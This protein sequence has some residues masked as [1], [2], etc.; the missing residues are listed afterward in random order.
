MWDN[1]VNSVLDKVFASEKNYP[2]NLSGQLECLHCKCS[3]QTPTKA[4]ASE[5]SDTPF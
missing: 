4:V 1:E 2:I 3:G 5:D